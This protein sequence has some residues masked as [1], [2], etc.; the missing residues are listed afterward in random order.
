MHTAGL[1]MSS[2]DA[3]PNTMKDEIA[4]HYPD[5]VAP[6]PL[7]D[8]RPNVTSWEYYRRVAEGE[9]EMPQLER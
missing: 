1:R 8:S 5:Y 9:E 6:P 7:D 2:W 3:M 4:E